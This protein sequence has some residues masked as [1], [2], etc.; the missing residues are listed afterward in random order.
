MQVDPLLLCI[1]MDNGAPMA[2]SRMAPEQHTAELGLKGR[3]VDGQ[4]LY[5]AV[6]VRSLHGQHTTWPAHLFVPVP[7]ADKALAGPKP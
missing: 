7:G 6:L 2:A 3:L 5:R 1:C 4:D